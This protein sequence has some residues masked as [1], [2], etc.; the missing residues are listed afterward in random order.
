MDPLTIVL[1]QYF[2]AFPN[3]TELEKD[4]DF[5]LI[6]TYDYN[7]CELQDKQENI[8]M[9]SPVQDMVLIYYIKTQLNPLAVFMGVVPLS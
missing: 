3:I 1:N 5:Y 6:K 4:F 2:S 9:L 7:E 8:A